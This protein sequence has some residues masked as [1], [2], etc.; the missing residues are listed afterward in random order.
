MTKKVERWGKKIKYIRCWPKVNETYVQRGVYYLDLEWVQNWN[1][2]I[3][4]MNKNKRGSPFKFPESLIELQA[5]WTQYHS[6]RVAEGITISLVEFANLPYSNDYTT[7]F[8][9]VVKLKTK[10]P[11]AKSKNISI[12]TDGSGIKMGMSGEYLED[13]YGDGK[14]K[15]IKVVVSAE[16]YDK[17]ILKVEV[18][19]EGQ[20]D[21]EPEIAEKH[22]DQLF[23][24]GYNIKEFFGDG[25]FDKNSLFDLCDFYQIN[26]KIKIRE[27]AVINSE[28]SWRRNIEVKKYLKLGYKKW[29]KKNNYGRR[30][31]G[32]EG[33]FS[34]VKIIYGERVRSKKEENKCA[35][36]HR[37]FWAYQKIK[38]YA[39]EK[40]A[41]KYKN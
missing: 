19:I 31:T 3:E 35:E 37:R 4:K 38:R 26:P 12:S 11:S 6:Y 15:Y 8:R 5:V 30:W 14:R 1:E 13:K 28:N 41:I 24:E 23:K 2:E 9:R 34:A 27:T 7:I 10:M 17:D 25:S 29:A 22:L 16:P 21:S 20:G 39:E 36:V 18:S 40:I 32:T 33:I